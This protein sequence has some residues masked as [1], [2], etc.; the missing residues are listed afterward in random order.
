MSLTQDIKRHLRNWLPPV[1]VSALRKTPDVTAGDRQAAGIEDRIGFHGDY[2][3]WADASA[4]SAGY[5]SQEILKNVTQATLKVKQGEAAYE[6][7]SVTFDTL[8]CE[9]PLLSCIL[10]SA[11]CNRGHL[12]VVDFGGS[13]GSL[14]FQHAVFLQH[15]E[16]VRWNIVEQP[17]YVAVGRDEIADNQL[18][19]FKTVEDAIHDTAPQVLVLRCVLQYLE[20]PYEMLDRLLTHPWQMIVIDRTALLPDKKHDRLTVQTVPPS[21][22]EASYPAWF[23]SKSKLHSR[24][25]R[26]Y[27]Q[28][29]SWQNHDH[30]ALK[31][32]VTSFEGFCFMA[33]PISG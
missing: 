9:W 33:R 6:R 13:L 12:H 5:D 28:H 4:A 3:T 29:V 20:R 24:F 32:D 30:Y 14:Y 25:D 19:F 27:R 31:N 18:Q 1:V 17:H 23:L 15:L 2:R 26:T 10:H 16:S 8:D 7:D 22:Y 11:A 21:I